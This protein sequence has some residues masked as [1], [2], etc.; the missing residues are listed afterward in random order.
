MLFLLLSENNFVYCSDSGSLVKYP[1][2]IKEQNNLHPRVN[3][4]LKLSL[5]FGC[6]LAVRENH[7]PEYFPAYDHNKIGTSV[8]RG[9]Y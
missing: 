8:F 6:M 9:W 1:R 7:I 3:P 5:L 2:Q 4:C